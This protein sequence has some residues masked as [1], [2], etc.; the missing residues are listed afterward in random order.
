MDNEQSVIELGK[1]AL[2]QNCG[3]AAKDQ[4]RLEHEIKLVEASKNVFYM[5]NIKRNV[6]AH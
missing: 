3:W 2:K 1:A 6:S 5:H 4:Q